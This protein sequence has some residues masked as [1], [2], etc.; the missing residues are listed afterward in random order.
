MDNLTDHERGEYDAVHDHAVKD[1]ESP[2]YYSG[3]DSEFFKSAS[4]KEMGAIDCKLGVPHKAS[5][6]EEYDTGYAEQYAI[7]Q[8]QGIPV[9]SDVSKQDILKIIDELFKSCSESENNATEEE[10][11]MMLAFVAVVYTTAVSIIGEY[12]AKT[13]ADQYPIYAREEFINKMRPKLRVV[14]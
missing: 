13:L 1:N 6:S 2:D 7:E 3:Y 4:D 12:G 9:L 10:L 11:P 8:N 5:Q 14:K